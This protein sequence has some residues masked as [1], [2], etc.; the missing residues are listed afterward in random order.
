MP[1]AAA[2]AAGIGAGTT[3]RRVYDQAMITNPSAVTVLCF[4]DSNTHGAPGDDPEYRRLA[5]DV[6]W[7]GQLQNLLGTGWNVI[8]EGLSGRTID[9][10][11]ADRPGLNGR[12]YIVPCVLSH[13][14]LDV[15]VLMLG[16]ND[17]KTEFSRTV[18]E[19]TGQWD[20]FLD[21][22]FANVWTRDDTAPAVILVSPARLN[23]DQPRFATDVASMDA[24]SVQKS[25]QLA[26]AYREVADRRGLV[27]FDA[28]TVAE[29][30][31]DGLHL[32]AEANGRL[33]AALVPVI[34]ASCEN[35]ASA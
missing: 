17:L 28:A 7:T 27:Y 29:V 2:R 30:G 12:A 10:D 13:A 18:D 22:M 4:G 33:A 16:T 23:P 8:E 26:A 25:V 3:V 21:D 1:P 20:G 31:A 14:P 11:Y 32:T 15:I 34:R 9:L 35:R 5:P 24:E 19:I 6:R